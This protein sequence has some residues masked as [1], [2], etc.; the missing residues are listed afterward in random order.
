METGKYKIP[1][2]DFF[3]MGKAVEPA[4]E[5]YD[6]IRNTMN[7][8]FTGDETFEICAIRMKKA[9]SE[10]WEGYAS[11]SKAIAAGWFKEKEKAVQQAVRLE[12]ESQAEG[13]Y[14]TLNPCN[15]SLMSRCN[16][17]FKASVA[18]TRDDEIVFLNNLFIDIDPIRPSGVSS[19]DYEHQLALDLAY[20]LKDFLTSQNWPEPLLASSGNGAHLIVK[21]PSLA[22]TSENVDLVK[23]CL[24]VLDKKFTTK[25]LKIDEKVYNPARLTKLYG[26]MVRKGDHTQERPHRRAEIISCPS[27]AETVDIV[28]LRALAEEAA[29]DKR[30]AISVPASIPTSSQ[31]NVEHFLQEHGVEIQKVKTNGTSTLYVL[32]KCV[33]DESH[34]PGE[35]SIVQTAQG[36]L[37]YQCFHDSCRSRTWHDARKMIAGEEELSKYTEDG[38]LGMSSPRGRSLDDIGNSERLIDLFGERIKYCTTLK[39]WFVWDGRRWAIDEREAIVRFAKATARSIYQEAAREKDDTRRRLIASHAAKSQC[40]RAIREM[41]NLAKSA[42]GIP[43]KPTD[44]DA[45]PWL[46]NLENTMIDLKTGTHFAHDSERLVTKLAPVTELPDA[47]CPQ[48]LS[49]LDRIM[50]GNKELI[51]FLQRVVGYSLTG[52]TGGQCLFFLHGSGANGKSTF[53]EVIRAL[54]GDYAKQADFSTFLSRKGDGPRND[55]AALKGARFVSAVEC[56]DGK[57]LAESVIKQITGGDMITARFLFGEFFEYTPCFKVWL[58]ANNKPKI[59]KGDYAIWRRIHLVPFNVTIPEKERDPALK[60]RLKMEL[61]GIVNWA[62]E[63]CA[64]WRKGGLQVPKEV[65]AAT[66]AYKAEMD[67]LEGFISECCDVD[68][69]AKISV[70]ELFKAYGTWCDENGEDRLEKKDFTRK[71]IERGL[72]KERGTHG[73]TYWH[74]IGLSE[75]RYSTG[76]SVE[77]ASLGVAHALAPCPI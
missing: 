27:V 6:D 42:D 9:K 70:A 15:P 35:S 20:R 33:F 71:L 76:S 62:L 10:A 46:F 7:F 4:G 29:E 39:K 1:I 50:D 24:L 57:Q 40:G 36:K 49:F 31:F 72:V 45:D 61:P 74:G 23:K 21:L 2:N 17:R 18:R 5:Q 14:L 56:E 25:D 52:D 77:G 47:T 65:R 16:Q 51:A 30:L 54:L 64:A 28:C 68:R 43:I 13:I 66:A 41:V 73:Y 59:T 48:W 67:N 44:L 63:G 53:I 38:R 58:A 37:L 3:G 32:E 75:A 19:S 55:I 11:G 60:E 26:T 34:A 8:L 69:S 12:I 22:N